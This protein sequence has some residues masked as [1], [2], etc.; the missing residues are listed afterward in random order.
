LL[1][2]ARDIRRL[3]TVRV[4]VRQGTPNRKPSFDSHAILLEAVMNRS[5]V[6]AKALA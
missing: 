4:P 1:Q 2:L 5:H 6:Q 3:R